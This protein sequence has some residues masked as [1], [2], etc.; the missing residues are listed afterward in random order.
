MNT[1]VIKKVAVADLP[2]ESELWKQ[3]NEGSISLYPWDG[4][5]HDTPTTNFYMIYD[6]E[7]IGI[8]FVTNEKKPVGK[9]D[10]MNTAVYT[11]S[12]VELFFN[13]A[14]NSE[15]KYLNF[16]LSVTGYMLLGFG[17]DRFDR[18][19]QEIDFDILKI[20]TRVLPDE[21]WEAKFFIPFSLLKCYY[22]EITS[23]WTGNLQKLCEDCV[24]PHL[25]CWNLIT[26]EK[27]DFHRPECFGNL[28]L[29]T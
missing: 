25:G 15:K 14:P 21:G 18:V 11:D 2:M 20:E 5:Q 24:T 19:L 22:P 28:I 4:Y 12:C 3:G 6:E 9:A 16:E 27:P 17:A 8:K 13:A 29:E 26:S 10:G 1:Y 7:G 23:E